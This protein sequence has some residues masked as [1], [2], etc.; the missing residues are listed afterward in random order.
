MNSLPSW[1]SGHEV[2]RV[3]Q[4]I[5]R[6]RPFLDDRGDAFGAFA[7]AGASRAKRRRQARRARR[8]AFEAVVGESIAR[9]PAGGQRAPEVLDSGVGERPQSPVQSTPPSVSRSWLP[10]HSPGG[11]I[12][13]SGDTSFPIWT[14]SWRDSKKEVEDALTEAERAGWTVIPT[15]SGHR[16]GVMRCGEAS[17]SGC[18]V[19]IW[20]TP[21]NPGNHARQLCRALE[22]CPHEWGEEE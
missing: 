10:A 5:G 4:R 11:H 22:R 12:I 9:L 17:R 19:S 21:R 6:P 8:H 15:S 18:Q 13:A 7:Q 16:W 14:L 2:A 20:S 3:A 1:R